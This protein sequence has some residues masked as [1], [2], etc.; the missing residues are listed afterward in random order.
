MKYTFVLAMLAGSNATP[1][2]GY[3]HTPISSLAQLSDEPV[4]GS[5]LKENKPICTSW[6]AF[7]CV[8]PDQLVQIQS[9]GMPDLPTI[10][11]PEKGDE[12]KK[13]KK[14]E[15]YEYKAP[16]LKNKP[17]SADSVEHKICNGLN[18]PCHEI[19]A[20]MNN[21]SNDRSTNTKAGWSS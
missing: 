4:S 3:H 8:E 19:D 7:N 14:E 12:K 6:V 10:D 13:V 16:P 1:F 11:A 2:L 5:G 9:S 17:I 15:D 20:W 18:S 21:H